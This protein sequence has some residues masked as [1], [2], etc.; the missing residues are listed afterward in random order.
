MLPKICRRTHMYILFLRLRN[1]EL[2]VGLK[3]RNESIF[4]IFQGH[5]HYPK[6]I[7]QITYCTVNND[8]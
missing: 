3:C 5:T 1:W 8:R 6:I 2:A 7:V 4:V